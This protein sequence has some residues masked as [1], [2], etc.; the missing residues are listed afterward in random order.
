MHNQRTWWEV[1]PLDCLFRPISTSSPLSSSTSL[2]HPYVPMPGP[3]PLD[4]QL[5]EGIEM[6]I[7]RLAVPNFW[8]QSHSHNNDYIKDLPVWKVPSPTDEPDEGQF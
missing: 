3:G 5:E 8:L 2:I 4:V 7:E 6:L 1:L